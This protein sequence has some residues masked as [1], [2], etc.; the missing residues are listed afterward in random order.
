MLSSLIF[1][2]SHSVNI[3]NGQKPLTV[4]ITVLYTFA[5]G[6]CMYLT[7]RVTGNLVWPIL[8]HATTDPSGLLLVGGIDEGAAPSGGLGEIAGL[9]N[10][11]TIG[12]AL[13][14]MWFVRGR[15]QDTVMGSA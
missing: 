13:V 10:F 5:F 1:A 14:L 6:V 9:A 11:V 15:V 3:F 2:A 12:V 7:L 8:L 4:A